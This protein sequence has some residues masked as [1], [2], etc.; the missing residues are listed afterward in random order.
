MGKMTVAEFRAWS[1][2]VRLVEKVRERVPRLL[3]LGFSEKE[4]GDRELFL[5]DQLWEQA[6]G[7]PID[8]NNEVDEFNRT[9]KEIFESGITTQEFMEMVKEY[10]RQ[11]IDPNYQ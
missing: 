4:I 8:P 3:R 11:E 1:K 6:K 9:L 7:L 10:I 5:D 2:E